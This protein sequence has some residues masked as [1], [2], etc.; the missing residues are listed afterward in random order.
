MTDF[1]VAFENQFMRL[2]QRKSG[3]VSD[4]V[5]QVIR[6][7]IRAMVN[8]HSCLDLSGEPSDLISSLT[9]LDFVG[10]N[11]ESCPIV[12]SQD[13]LY[14][15]KYFH[16]ERE[17]A[18]MISARNEPAGAIDHE[19]LIN[20]INDQFEDNSDEQKLAAWIAGTRKLT[21]ITGGPGTGKTTTVRKI[22]ELLNPD[23]GPLDI[24]LAAPTGKAA[25][26]LAESLGSM[27]P[28]MTLHRLLGLRRDGRSW[29]HHPGNPI[30][31]DVLVVDEASM[32][33]LPMMHRL[34]AALPE[35]TRLILLGDPNQLPSVDTGNVLA[36]LCSE[37]PQ[38]SESF[39]REV[40]SIT[41]IKSGKV[42][43]KLVDAIC[44]LKTNYRFATDSEVGE[45]ARKIQNGDPE[46]TLSDGVHLTNSGNLAAS[47]IEPWTK[48]FELLTLPGTRVTELQTQF[49]QHRMLCSRRSGDLG[50]EHIN[51][52]LE[53]TLEQHALKN[54]GNPFY[55]GRPIM[56]TKNDYKL[57]LFNGDVGIC[58]RSEHQ[59]EPTEDQF[60]VHFPNQPQSPILASRLPPHETCFAMTV[61]KSQGSEFDHVHLILDEPESVN[62]TSLLTRE[63]LYTAVTR[64][65]QSITLYG[66][67]ERWQEAIARHAHRVSGMKQFL[68]ES[69]D[70]GDTPRETDAAPEDRGQ[71]DLF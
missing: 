25:M 67:T 42:T 66:S 61:H 20:T 19:N 22:L 49:D 51:Q 6:R 23:E 63:L 30:R 39:I 53:A 32:I 58:A 26:R 1:S 15:A 69:A 60:L 4:D 16:L 27:T 56:V 18:E 50:V 41:K 43:N 48:Y 5:N 68:A 14:L 9:H 59:S 34:L 38:F 36:D 3:S 55:H 8:Q 31:A 65:K 28:V 45:L 35:Q 10:T 21:I 70:L 62:S 29:R 57:G 17:L 11:A 46:L 64:A 44:E 47:I 12:L 54:A 24:K 7:L 71:L 37:P 40:H 52:L 13:K 33:D 2:L